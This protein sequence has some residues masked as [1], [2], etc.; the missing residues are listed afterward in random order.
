M[1]LIQTWYGPSIKE[2]VTHP[3]HLHAMNVK[4]TDNIEQELWPTIRPARV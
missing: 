2:I 4:M 3:A 1:E